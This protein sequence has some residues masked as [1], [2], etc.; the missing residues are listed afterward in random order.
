MG[1]PHASTRA[2]GRTA[3]RAGLDVYEPGQCL[4]AWLR[5]FSLVSQILASAERAVLCTSA[6]EESCSTRLCE[7]PAPHEHHEAGREVR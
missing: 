5:A 1:E 7:T 4:P 6:F 2:S 3:L